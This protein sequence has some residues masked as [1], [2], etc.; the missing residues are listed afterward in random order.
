LKRPFF[1]IGITNK[2]RSVFN[3]C[4]SFL[5]CANRNRI[6]YLAGYETALYYNEEAI[7]NAGSSGRSGSHFTFSI[8][9]SFS[10]G[11]YDDHA[12]FN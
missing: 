8:G 10:I 11:D 5:K 7:I 6:L 12:D 1:T 4:G 9:L 3:T 2:I